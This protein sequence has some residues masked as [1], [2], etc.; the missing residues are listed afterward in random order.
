M[1]DS[2][3]EQC[4]IP[5]NPS[6]IG[7]NEVGDVEVIREGLKRKRQQMLETYRLTN[8]KTHKSIDLQ[9][10]NDGRDD[11]TFVKASLLH[12]VKIL[13]DGSFDW[14]ETEDVDITKLD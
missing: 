6:W 13:N 2:E 1:E 14:N 3:K 7:Y 5:M 10:P 9:H 11:I 12:R 8:K 4:P